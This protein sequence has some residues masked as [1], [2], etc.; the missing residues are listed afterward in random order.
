[1]N[2]SMLI[3]ERSW[4]ILFQKS[5][6]L[7]EL[8]LGDLSDQF[9]N[10]SKRFNLRKIQK[11]DNM[12]IKELIQKI[13]I[14][15]GGVGVDSLFYDPE[16]IDICD[17]YYQQDSYFAVLTY[18]KEVVGGVGLKPAY[19]EVEPPSDICELKKL[20]LHKDYRN[21]GQGKYMFDFALKKAKSLGYKSIK[22]E[23][24]RRNEN[25]LEFLL[26]EQFE[27]REC[28]VSSEENTKLVFYK[29]L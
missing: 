8:L 10:L 9:S 26:R 18:R 11:K 12:A 24:E 28:S 19:D 4:S 5:V 15:R 17:S 7:A 21:K 29:R 1:M 14:Q 3:N 22:V 6:Q 20:Y 25:F 27:L 23:T 16:L 13:L 2:K